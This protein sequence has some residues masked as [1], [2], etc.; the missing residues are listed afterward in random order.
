MHP[1]TLVPLLFAT[2]ALIA[3]VFREYRW[4]RR[5]RFWQKSVG[6]MVRIHQDSDGESDCPVI[7]Y[8]FG[9]KRREQVCEFNLKTPSVGEEIPILV[10][11][12]TGSI[13]A[14]TK[15]DRWTLSVLLLLVITFLSLIAL[16]SETEVSLQK[17]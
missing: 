3:L 16:L 12:S 11:P 7:S 14:A 17:S 5:E 8:M 15:R 9:D 13:F 10:D 4:R 1:G 2:A 6:Y